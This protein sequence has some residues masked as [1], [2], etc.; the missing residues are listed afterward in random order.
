MF[1]IVQGMSCDYMHSVLLGVCRILLRLWI[2]SKY[3][4]EIW[5]LGTVVKQLDNRLCKIRPPSEI[6][7]TPRSI[8]NNLKFW[9][10]VFC[11][12][13]SIIV[14]RSFV[15]TSTVVSLAILHREK[16]MARKTIVSDH[17]SA[18]LYST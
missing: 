11:S 18:F 3:H 17:F 6:R 7:R 5:Y 8:E 4:G 14:W 15:A 9:K 12:C 2:D 1:D 13:P 10:G 16:R